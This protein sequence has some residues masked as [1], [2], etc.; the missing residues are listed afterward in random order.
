MIERILAGIVALLMGVTALGW[1]IDPA[2]AAQGLGMPLLEGLGRSTQVG[3]FTAFFLAI[4]TFC[5]LGIITRQT[6]WLYSAAMLLGFAAVMRTYAWATHGA[7][8]AA[9]L[10]AT[11]VIMTA[12]LVTSAWLMARSRAERA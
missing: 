9:A 3:D 6:Q 11:E 1:L 4:T 7:E 8:F 12:L 2:G 10:I 5:A